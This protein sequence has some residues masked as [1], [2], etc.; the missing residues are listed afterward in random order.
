MN[1]LL[2]FSVYDENVGYCQSMNFMMA[3]I[4][5]INGGNEKE[6]FWL[7]SAIA[8]TSSV[9]NDEYL[10]EGIRGFYLKH[11]PLLQQYFY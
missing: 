3:F 2:V 11:F 10:F 9:T 4:M 7:F 1:A 5:M 6:A 8:K